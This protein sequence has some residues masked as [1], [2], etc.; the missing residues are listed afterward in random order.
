M[1]TMTYS[2]GM[3]CTNIQRLYII[4]ETRNALLSKPIH[5]PNLAPDRRS[6]IQVQNV[7]KSGGFADSQP[8]IQQKQLDTHEKWM[9]QLRETLLSIVRSELKNP[10]SPQSFELLAEFQSTAYAKDKNNNGDNNNSGNGVVSFFKK[11]SEAIA[12]QQ[13]GQRFSTSILQLIQLKNVQDITGIQLSENLQSYDPQF[14][15]LQ[16]YLFAEKQPQEV[17]WFNEVKSIV[18]ELAMLE[19]LLHANSQT[20][21]KIYWQEFEKLEILMESNPMPYLQNFLLFDVC[22]TLKLSVFSFFISIAMNTRA[23]YLYR[24]ITQ[25]F[26]SIFSEK[27]ELQEIVSELK[28]SMKFMNLE[29][30]LHKGGNKQPIK[31]LLHLP[32]CQ[33]CLY[34]FLYRNEISSQS[35]KSAVEIIYQQKINGFNPYFYSVD[36]FFDANF[37]GEFVTP[38]LPLITADLRQGIKINMDDFLFRWL[39]EPFLAEVYS[40]YSDRVLPIHCFDLQSPPQIFLL[41][42]KIPTFCTSLLLLRILEKIALCEKS[43]SNTEVQKVYKE[44]KLENS[45]KDKLFSWAYGIF[46]ELGSIS[47]ILK[48]YSEKNFVRTDLLEFQALQKYL[49]EEL[50]VIEAN[51]STEYISQYLNKQF[52]D[53]F[54]NILPTLLQKSLYIHKT[55][56]YTLQWLKTFRDA[57]QQFISEWDQVEDRKSR[58]TPID[59]ASEYQSESLQLS[60]RQLTQQWAQQPPGLP[61]IQEMLVGIPQA[62]VLYAGGNQDKDNHQKMLQLYSQSATLVKIKMV[63]K[64]LGLK[65]LGDDEF[66]IVMLDLIIS[67]NLKS[68][69]LSQQLYARLP[70]LEP[71]DPFTQQLILRLFQLNLAQNNH[72]RNMELLKVRQWEQDA[73]LLISFGES[74]FD[75]SQKLR[76]QSLEEYVRLVLLRPCYKSNEQTLVVCFC[77]WMVQY[78]ENSLWQQLVVDV[79]R[80]LI[81]ERTVQIFNEETAQVI[82]LYASDS[83]LSKIMV[84][85]QD[86]EATQNVQNTM[87]LALAQLLVNQAL[88]EDFDIDCGTKYIDMKKVRESG[89]YELFNGNLVERGM[90]MNLFNFGFIQVLLERVT[91]KSTQ[92]FDKLQILL[93]VA[94]QLNQ[95][96]CW[97]QLMSEAVVSYAR[98]QNFTEEQL[99]TLVQGLQFDD[100]TAENLLVDQLK[101][102]LTSGSLPPNFDSIL[103][104]ITNKEYQSQILAVIFQ[105]TYLELFS[106]QKLNQIIQKLRACIPG[107]CTLSDELVKYVSQDKIATNI[108]SIQV[109]DQFGTKEE[110]NNIICNRFCSAGFQIEF[111]LKLLQRK[112]LANNSVQSL[113]LSEKIKPETAELVLQYAQSREVD[114][115]IDCFVNLLNVFIDTDGHAYWQF[116]EQY[117]NKFIK[118]AQLTQRYQLVLDIMGHMGSHEELNAFGIDGFIL[119]SQQQQ[120]PK[121]SVWGMIQRYLQHLQ[122]VESVDQISVQ[123]VETLVNLIEEYDQPYLCQFTQLLSISSRVHES[124]YVKLMLQKVANIVWDVK[125]SDNVIRTQQQ[126]SLVNRIFQLSLETSIP[127]QF[128]QQAIISILQKDPFWEL[129]SQIIFIALIKLCESNQLSLANDI[130]ERYQHPVFQDIS[131]QE[132]EQ[133]FAS[134]KHKITSQSEIL[135]DNLQTFLFNIFDQQFVNKGEIL[136]QIA[137]SIIQNASNF[138]A[139]TKLLQANFNGDVQDV[140]CIR[141]LLCTLYEYD[142]EATLPTSL[143]QY[144][145]KNL[146]NII[147]NIPPEIVM[148]Y[149]ISACNV[150]DSA[151][152]Q[153]Y[154]YLY[155]KFK[156]QVSPQLWKCALASADNLQDYSKGY[157]ILNH[158]AQEKR[159]QNSDWRLDTEQQ[160]LIEIN[161]IINGS[162]DLVKGW[163]LTEQACNDFDIFPYNQIVSLCKLLLLE[164]SSPYVCSGTV[165]KIFGLLQRKP[166]LHQYVSLEVLAVIVDLVI[167]SDSTLD[168]IEVIAYLLFISYTYGVLVDKID[169]NKVDDFLQKCMLCAYD[170]LPVLV[171][172]SMT[173]G[174]ISDK[175]LDELDANKDAQGWLEQVFNCGYIIDYILDI[176]TQNLVNMCEKRQYKDKVLDKLKGYI[177]QQ[178]HQQIKFKD[179]H[180]DE[181]QDWQNYDKQEWLLYLKQDQDWKKWAHN[182]L[183]VCGQQVVGNKFKK[184]KSKKNMIYAIEK[185]LNE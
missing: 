86:A 63:V 183:V 17:D 82:L 72:E 126:Q 119:A 106:T 137:I 144:V 20:F 177:K 41:Q 174:D 168:K 28:Q 165:R 118:A 181:Y 35:L 116:G 70:Q 138:F 95:R 124:Q 153:C 89:N 139:A 154:A 159:E 8:Q 18:L 97:T 84:L 78:L 11:I 36:Y 125:H 77:F 160:K 167:V 24:H 104:Q 87:Q 4:K 169:Q 65:Q 122:N 109:F 90:Q 56:Q 161:I 31:K 83:V 156:Q 71:S 76:E 12:S 133:F 105:S 185:E 37:K 115:S 52:Q 175:L 180:S 9:Q 123:A 68:E 132:I 158:I 50:K 179:I 3:Q 22:D 147:Y 57:R 148:K 59:L 13:S 30:V 74:L 21:K 164:Q 23:L 38:P 129:P 176:D 91:Q 172:M 152:L 7:K 51:G 166:H 120:L 143:I 170:L 96:Y 92:N 48:Q 94:Q 10:T 173:T 135:S 49:E 79:I 108:N 114:L 107:A 149:A 146:Q 43:L 26:L 67:H 151:T 29:Y 178:S 80:M 33:F 60:I 130:L 121:S 54:D 103:L 182:K 100:L 46:Y 58:K 101:E 6:R 128:V 163:D 32:G 136:A 93:S 14:E 25:Y 73:R 112:Q 155:S 145:E 141:E 110:A 131:R 140:R 98:A 47:L 142:E 5:R 39:E 53:V 45:E 2:L 15:L 157:I 75:S 61:F 42:T 19:R 62:L 16:M 34:S 150:A 40:R 69:Y 184:L 64:G 134:V 171:V 99:F 102:S 27:N 162:K 127:V 117:T 88:S 85:V 111:G 66:C 113:L 81:D 44:L 55:V 1:S